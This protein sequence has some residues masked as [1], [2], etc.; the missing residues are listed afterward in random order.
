MKRRPMPK[1][2]SI[3]APGRPPTARRAVAA[4]RTCAALWLAMALLLPGQRCSAGDGAAA[5][6]APTY[7]VWHSSRIGGGGYVQSVVFCPSDPR[8]VY[9]TVD[10]C[11]PFRSDDGGKS[12][13]FIEGGFPPRRG[14]YIT[15]D[16]S[17]DPRTADRLAVAKSN[18]GW[19]AAEGIYV[20]DDG[21]RT[22]TRTLTAE[23]I[24]GASVGQILARHPRNPDVLLTAA[25]GSG[26]FRSAD[27]G[28]TWRPC[29]L[30][31][32][33]PRDLRFDLRSPTASGSAPRAVRSG[34]ANN[35]R[36]SRAASIAAA[37]A[38]RPGRRFPSSRP[39]SCSRTPSTPAGSTAS[40]IARPFD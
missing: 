9:V 12:W 25:I 18:N 38:A 29:G 23:F 21:G 22:W 37:T 28:Q 27:N 7:G 11:G 15:R 13:R 16:L 32:T 33:F 40:S 36:P 19:E 30:K 10:V 34:A 6:V 14:A 31:G 17:V 4:R 20:S 8:R 1:L 26:V 35:R 2:A 3:A 24:G 39:T 5:A